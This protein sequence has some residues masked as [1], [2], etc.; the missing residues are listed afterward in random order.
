M[1]DSTKRPPRRP[2]KGRRTASIGGTS[3]SAFAGYAP[4]IGKQVGKKAEQKQ[5]AKK[6]PPETETP[7]DDDT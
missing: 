4:K 7:L 2:R 6:S 5:P 1:T 3:Q